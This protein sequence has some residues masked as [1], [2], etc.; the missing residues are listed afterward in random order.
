MTTPALTRAIRLLLPLS[1]ALGAT[2]VAALPATATNDKLDAALKR[3][4]APASPG[5]M[6][7]VLILLHESSGLRKGLGAVRDPVAKRALLGQRLRDTAASSQKDLR[8]W[9]DAQGVDYHPFWIANA[10]AARVPARLLPELAGR[11]EVRT[12]ESDAPHPVS[13]PLPSPAAKATLAGEP[14][15][16]IKIRA[17]DVWALGYKGQGVVVAGQDTGYQWDHPA[18]KGKYRGWNGVSADHDYAWHDAIRSF[19]NAGTTNSC[20]LDSPFPCDDNGHGTHTMG[21]MIG[22]DGGANPIGVAPDAKWI[23]CRNMEAGDGRP[24]TYIECFEWFVEPTDMAGSNPDAAM[25]PDVIN[26]SW[27]CPPSELCDATATNTMESA[28]DNVRAAGIV[29]VVSAGNGGSA[30]DTVDDPAAIYASSFT[31]GATN[32]SDVIASF[33]SR[34]MSPTGLLKPNVSAPGVSVCSSVPTDSYSCSYS[35]TSMAGPHVAGAVALIISANPALR[36]DPDTIQSILESTAVPLTSSQGCGGFG[37]TDV[38]NAVYGYGRIDA[39][40]AVQA[41]L[42]LVSPQVFSD[43]FE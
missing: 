7:D 38:P 12:I 41:A 9:L 25:A 17:P 8:Q 10:I 4:L 43:G 40:A 31:V 35:G 32:S 22:D 3:R 19:I 20:G 2:S 21:T 1:L 6:M 18:L 33:S 37:P 34:G 5:Q 16:V 27:G 23:G 29:V 14:W 28:V 42:A 36:G 39:Y 11:V 26:N 15:G 24:S 13:E 30:C